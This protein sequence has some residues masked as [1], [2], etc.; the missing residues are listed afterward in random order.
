[1]RVNYQIM[2]NVIIPNY[3]NLCISRKTLKTCPDFNCPNRRVNSHLNFAYIYIYIYIYIH[4]FD[5]L[6][7]LSQFFVLKSDLV[8]VCFSYLTRQ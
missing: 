5:K 4:F 7:Y 8:L 3:A 1:M 2:K 6:P